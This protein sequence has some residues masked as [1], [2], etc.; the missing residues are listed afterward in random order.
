M[1]LFSKGF[2]DVCFFLRASSIV[3]HIKSV[4]LTVFR[5]FR[6]YLKNLSSLIVYLIISCSVCESSQQFAQG[7]SLQCYG[8]R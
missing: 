3:L 1:K 7:M 2:F 4:K 8:M 6:T 5:S